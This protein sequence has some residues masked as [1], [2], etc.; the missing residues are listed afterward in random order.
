MQERNNKMDW[1]E[2]PD[3]HSLDE[4]KRPKFL[5]SWMEESGIIR[6]QTVMNH[7]EASRMITHLST[8][9]TTL[10]AETRRIGSKLGSFSRKKTLV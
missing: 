6:G 7:E 1:A 3:Y 10:Y 4:K 9:E 5:V 8:L 2:Q